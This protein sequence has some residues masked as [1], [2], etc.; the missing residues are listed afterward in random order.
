MLTSPLLLG[1]VLLIDPKANNVDVSGGATIDTRGGLAP[2]QPGQ[3]PE[4][5]LRI[6][7]SP[8]AAVV[9]QSRVRNRRLSFEY[10]PR[11][12]LV[13][14]DSILGSSQ[15]PGRPLLF[16]QLTSRYS[17]D[18]SPRWSWTATLGGSLGEQDYSLQSGG[19]I[20]GDGSEAEAGVDSEVQPTQAGL[21][22]DPIIVTGGLAG[23]F[24]FTAR[25]APLH[26][27]TIGP[28]VSLQR[29]VS[30]P[31]T[32]GDG[33]TVSFDQTS[34]ELATSYAWGASR[35]DTVGVTAVGG[36]ADFG[37]VN[38][39]QAYASGALNWRHR[40]RPRLDSELVGGVFFTRQVRS[41]VD[42]TGVEVDSSA[43]PLMPVGNAILIG[44][45]LERSR[46]RVTADVNLGSQAYFD[47]VQGSVLPLSGGGAGVSV[48]LPPDWTMGLNAS[49]YTPPVSPTE[50][51][52][53]QAGDPTASRTTLSV[54][55]PVSYVVNQNMSLELGTLIT[56]RGPSVA[57]GIPDPT[58]VYSNLID[59]M[60]VDTGTPHSLETV[61]FDEI[62]F[63]PWRFTQAEFWVY[64]AFQF[65][66]TTASSP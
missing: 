44:R 35:I 64:V 31:P 25:L 43:V 62:R 21:V 28:S 37:A 18:L 50:S 7:L 66:F 15:V 51:E 48:E 57:S 11:A 59:D 46:V 63:D 1:L 22:D 34:Y 4:P 52:R 23:G 17:A 39:T 47:P 38:G 30:E 9:Y 55:T 40:L 14:S 33:S 42:D 2:S 12:F 29:L 13:L 26:T 5:V 53:R 27:L 36:Y 65:D 54:R 60:G 41:P 32:S 19:L 8:R 61:P 6:S 20:Q 49:F 10:T 16:H 56:A 3:P 58:Q 45:V 24:G